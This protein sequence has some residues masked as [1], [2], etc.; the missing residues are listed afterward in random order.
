[1]QNLLIFDDLRAFVAVAKSDSISKAA[2][3]LRLAQPALSRRLMRLERCIGTRLIER[4]AQ[5]IKLTQ[6]GHTFFKPAQ[7]AVSA[8]VA[9]ERNL[10]SFARGN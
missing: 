4:H 5:G 1:M 10:Q 6:A 3:T 8:V 9:L 7:R 2:V